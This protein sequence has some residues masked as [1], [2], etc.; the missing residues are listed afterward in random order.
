MKCPC[1]WWRKDTWCRPKT[2]RGQK[3]SDMALLSICSSHVWLFPHCKV[4]YVS[5]NSGGLPPH[6]KCSREPC[7]IGY[8]STGKNN[9]KCLSFRKFSGR[10]GNLPTL[11]L[12][13]SWQHPMS[14]PWSL[15]IARNV[16][17]FIWLGN[18]LLSVDSVPCDLLQP[19]MPFS[20]SYTAHW[21]WIFRQSIIRRL[22]YHP[23]PARP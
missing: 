15:L 14:E 1:Q 10:F 16:N 17:F 5:K 3:S 2:H 23:N 6:F 19:I 22:V 7:T 4:N 11:T 9:I 18:I 12:R 8:L 20:D 13:L 21:N